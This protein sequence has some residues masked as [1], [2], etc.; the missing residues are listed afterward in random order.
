MPYD[1]NRPEEQIEDW[2]ILYGGDYATHNAR[3]GDAEVELDHERGLYVRLEEGSGYMAQ[4]CSHRIPLA[5]LLRLME[6]AG[7]RVEKAETSDGARVR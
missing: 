3:G 1:P 6:N 5:V 7:Y 4:S 2:T